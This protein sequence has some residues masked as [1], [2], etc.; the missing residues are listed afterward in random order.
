MS[1]RPTTDADLA[2]L[3]SLIDALRA[4]GVKTFQGFGVTV[5]LFPSAPKADDVKP[6]DMEKALKELSAT[7]PM[8][9]CGH[10]EFAHNN[11][12]CLAG[13]PAESCAPKD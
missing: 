2:S 8:C 11:G 1:E 3:E 7:A 12:Q 4:K 5:E 6:G 10:E 9:R 13:C